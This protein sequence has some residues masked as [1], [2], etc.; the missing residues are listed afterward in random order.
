MTGVYTITNILDGKM[1]IGCATD[2][3]IRLGHH[4]NDLI[5]NKH[6]NTHLQNAFN[7]VGESNFIFEVLEECEEQFIYSQE[8]YWC[9]ILNVHNRLYGYNLRPTK[10][11]GKAGCAE[12]TREKI[13]LS[14]KLK[15]SSYDIH[16]NVGYKHREE[17][18][19]KM[20][21]SKK[22]IKPKKEN[23]LKGIET[24]K[25]NGKKWHT[26]ETISKMSKSKLGKKRPNFKNIK[27]YPILQ[28]DVNMEL[29][30]EWSSISEASKDLNI[31]STALFAAIKR[32]SFTKKGNFWKRKLVPKD[33]SNSTT[34]ENG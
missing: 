16:P 12:S 26:E 3:N 32:G 23:V 28:L 6:Q 25:N 21:N 14:I 5:G 18:K 15:N 22:G 10:P 24:R 17:S 30:K 9:T 11:D 20:S 19:I 33:E 8:H 2:V 31:K 29:I 7:K 1:Y 13:R 27:Q 34:T 4:R